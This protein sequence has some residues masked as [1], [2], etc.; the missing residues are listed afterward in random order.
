MSHGSSSVYED[1]VGGDQSIFASSTKLV[2]II[3]HPAAAGSVIIYD[4]PSASTKEILRL[5]ANAAGL[6]IPC[7][8]LKPISC[9]T[10]IIVV[11]AGASN[12]VTVL[13]GD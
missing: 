12:A 13:Y 10:S 11:L 4:G 6:S 9:T 8:L 5:T 7:M 1:T 3:F 2:G